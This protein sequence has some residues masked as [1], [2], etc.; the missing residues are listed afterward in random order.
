MSPAKPIGKIATARRV[1]LTLDL[2]EVEAT[3][4]ARLARH[5]DVTTD[6][7]IVDAL[8]D[9]FANPTSKGGRS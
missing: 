5:L 6:E 7:I 3:Q 8:R 2:P 9:H 4:L 1:R